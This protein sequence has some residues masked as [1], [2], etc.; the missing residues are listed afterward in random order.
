MRDVL[1]SALQQS[2]QMIARNLD[3]AAQEANRYQQAAAMWPNLSGGINYSYNKSAVAQN[4]LTSST[5]S[6]GFYYSLNLNQPI[7]HWGALKAA[8]D[9][10][11]LQIKMSERQYADAYRQLTLTLRSQYLSLIMQKVVV[12][13]AR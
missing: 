3:L 10:A 11:R 4:S 12:R 9:I 5:L 13:N 1:H 2:P 8:A 7:Y 6:Q